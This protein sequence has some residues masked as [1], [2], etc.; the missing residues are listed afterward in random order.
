MQ[1]STLT[2]RLG[3]PIHQQSKC[4]FPVSQYGAREGRFAPR[5]QFAKMHRVMRRSVYVFF[6]HVFALFGVTRKT[7]VSQIELE[8]INNS[9]LCA[10]ACKI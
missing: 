7:F 2:F 5:S 3:A 4:H 9:Q 1:P 8:I 10:P 6:R